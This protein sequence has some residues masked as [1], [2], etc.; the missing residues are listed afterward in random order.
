MNHAE[1]CVYPTSDRLSPHC[2]ECQGLTVRSL[3]TRHFE[4][5]MGCD[6]VEFEAFCVEAERLDQVVGRQLPTNI[7]AFWEWIMDAPALRIQ[8]RRDRLVRRDRSLAWTGLP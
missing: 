8:E 7:A 2:P 1:T 5:L 4:R 3:D 6:R